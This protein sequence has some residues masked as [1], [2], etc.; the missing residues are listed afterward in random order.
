MGRVLRTALLLTL[1]NLRRQYESGAAH[2]EDIV[3]LIYDRIRAAG[4]DHVWIHLVPEETALKR[5]RELGAWSPDRPL[6]GVPFA[7]KD[8]IDVEGLPTTAGCPAFSYVPPRTAGAG[9]KALD[10]GAILIGKTN[11]DQFATGLVGTRSPYGACSSIYHADYI[12]GGSSSGSA[13]AVAK[14]EV[15]FALGTDTAGSGR[16]PAAFNGIVG[17]KPTRGLVSAAGVV[18]ACRSLDC[19]SVFSPDVET[20]GRVLEVLA[21]V[22]EGD[23]YSRSGQPQCDRFTVPKIGIPRAHQMQFFRDK[24]AADCWRR[25][26]LKTSDTELTEIDLTPFQQAAEL[27]YSGPFVAERYA[28]V[29]SFVASRPKSDFDPT[30][31]D[32]ILSGTRYSAVELF[33]AQYQLQDLRRTVTKIFEN[34]DALLLPTSPT[35]YRIAEVRGN[36]VQLNSRLGTY[37]NFVNLLD[38]CAIAVPAGLRD[39]GLPFGVTFMAPSFSDAKLLRLAHWW[40]GSP[41]RNY[42]QQPTG[43]ELAVVGAHLAGQPLNHQLTSRGA[44]LV[45]TTT[46]APHYRLFALKNSTPPKPGLLRVAE[47]QPNGIEVEVWQLTKEAFASFVAEIPP[48]MGIGNLELVDGSIVK[49]FICEPYALEGANEITALGGWRNYLES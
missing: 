26:L 36:P 39:D 13:V 10:A 2:P 40:E 7:V 30:V 48:P 44:S 49:G 41:L 19:V 17:V 42:L 21:D 32:I 6:F 4:D 16:V 15:C 8:N 20:G 28:A 5:A 45:R 29:G 27:L 25:A 1:Q 22:D 37:T 23:P 46:T 31:R 3:R 11:M 47:P 9:Q 18:P 38:L 14:G 34:I 12:S 35:I 24:A 43:I 33:N